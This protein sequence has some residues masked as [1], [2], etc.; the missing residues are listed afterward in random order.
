M[1]WAFV[2]QSPT[3]LAAQSFY[4]LLIQLFALRL[5][6]DFL[7]STSPPAAGRVFGAD[8]LRPPSESLSILRGRRRTKNPYRFTCMCRH[9]LVLKTDGGGNCVSAGAATFIN[10]VKERKKKH[11]NLHFRGCFGK[12]GEKKLGVPS[13]SPRGIH[14]T[15]FPRLSPYSLSFTPRSPPSSPLLPREAGQRNTAVDG[16]LTQML[17]GPLGR[18]AVQGPAGC[19]CIPVGDHSADAE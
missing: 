15:A 14:P 13:N 6:S 19:F 9:R 2:K 3:F 17:C 11:K 16:Q 1:I 7:C 5:G 8:Y 18:Q 4:G 10:P 12:R